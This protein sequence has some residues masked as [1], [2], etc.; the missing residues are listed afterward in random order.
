M[1]RFTNKWLRRIGIASVWVIGLGA[2]AVAAPGL[3][4]VTS[5]LWAASTELVAPPSVPDLP[6]ALPPVTAPK[7]VLPQPSD[8]PPADAAVQTPR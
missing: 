5:D 6:P 2:S 1:E 3:I 8:L 7:L 4:T